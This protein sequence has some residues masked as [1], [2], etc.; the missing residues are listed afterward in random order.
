M[1]RSQ[2]HRIPLEMD[3]PLA[4]KAEPNGAGGASPSR[5]PG[6]PL[7]PGQLQDVEDKIAAALRTCFDPEIPVNIYELGLIY[8]IDVEPPG[9]VRVRMTLTS[10]AC[11]AAASLP[12]EVETKTKGVAGVT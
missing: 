12:A 6:E 7:S 9:K 8:G 10:P 3:Q 11:P 1:D 5:P 4:S 2:P